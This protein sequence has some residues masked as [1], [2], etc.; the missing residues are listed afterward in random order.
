[1]LLN[2]QA[3]VEVGIYAD[4]KVKELEYVLGINDNGPPSFRGQA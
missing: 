1:M 4:A 3:D 2:I